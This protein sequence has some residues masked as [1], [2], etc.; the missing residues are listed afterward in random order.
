MCFRTRTKKTY[1]FTYKY[2][3]RRII[4]RG[5][6]DIRNNKLLLAYPIMLLSTFYSL[7]SC[8]IVDTFV[9]ERW[10]TWQI[11]QIFIR[12]ERTYAMLCVCSRC[13]RTRR[14]CRPCYICTITHAID[15]AWNV[16][17]QRLVR[18]EKV[19]VVGIVLFKHWSITK[20]RTDL[21]LLLNRMCKVN[22]ITSGEVRSKTVK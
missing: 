7:C 16:C 22:L 1:T 17:S 5:K 6:S 8:V 19:T 18:L 21:V 4:F 20:A 2:S 10:S 9:S 12:Y 3:A 13:T 14:C 11:A 15:N